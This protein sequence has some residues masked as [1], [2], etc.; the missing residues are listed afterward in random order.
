MC[1]FAAQNAAP[2]G[3]SYKSRPTGDHDRA[4]SFAQTA[5]VDKDLWRC[6]PFLTISA[7]QLLHTVP[8]NNQSG[9]FLRPGLHTSQ[10]IPLTNPGRASDFPPVAGPC[11]FP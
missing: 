11:L 3:K 8:E 5:Q 1:N 6:F 7:R 2:G 10:Q 9:F 4:A